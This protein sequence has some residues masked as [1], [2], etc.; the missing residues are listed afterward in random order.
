MSG[1]E[2]ASDHTLAKVKAYVVEQHVPHIKWHFTLNNTLST[3]P[4]MHGGKVLPSVTSLKTFIP[5]GPVGPDIASPGWQCTLKLPHSFLAGDRKEIHAVGRGATEDAASEDACCTAMAMLL[6]ED[7]NNV[8]LRPKHWHVPLGILMQGVSTIIAAGDHA[9]MHQPLAVH[10]RPAGG[11]RAGAAMTPEAKSEAVSDVIRACLEGHGGSFD[12][13]HIRRKW[14]K[15]PEGDKPPWAV[16]DDLLTRGQLRDFIESH[17][18]FE[19]RPRDDGKGMIITWAGGPSFASQTPPTNSS[20][21]DPQQPLGA[22]EKTII[23]PEEDKSPP[24]EDKSPPRE[25]P[26]RGVWKYATDE[27]GKLLGPPFSYQFYGSDEQQTPEEH[28]SWEAPAHTAR[29]STGSTEQPLSQADPSAD[30]RQVHGGGADQPQL[31]LH[32]GPSSSAACGWV[33]VPEALDVMD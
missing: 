7:A 23:V 20:P 6:I 14:V 18:E 25:I 16:L 10:V 8:V 19:W 17:P 24:E 11:G 15:L 21:T 30:K 33:A 29:T 32:H 31:A 13:S 2:T 9:V 4:G 3:R 26:G 27:N 12:P 28:G 1:A 22:Q 5:L